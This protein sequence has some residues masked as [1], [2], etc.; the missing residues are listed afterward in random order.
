MGINDILP[1]QAGAANDFGASA[2]W[3]RTWA[4]VAAVLLLGF[5]L[6]CWNL[7]GVGYTSDEVAELHLGHASLADAVMDRDSDLFPPLY[8]ITLVGWLRAWGSDS[9]AR[10]LSVL[11]GCLTLVVVWRAGA[12]LLGE[13]DAVW[14]TL[15]L[16]T[17][18]FH[19]LHSRDGR[20]YA[21]YYLMAAL[22]FWAA[23][24]VMRRGDWGNWC[25]LIVSTAAA[26]YT[27]YF[28]GPLAVVIWGVVIATVTPRDGW[29]RALVAGAL[30][31][32]ALAPS[33]LLLWRAMPNVTDDPIVAEFDVEA[34]GYSYVSQ[35]TGHTAGPTMNELRAMPVREGVRQFLPWIGALGFAY[36]V[37]GWQAWRRLTRAQF[38][39]L[40]LPL[41]GLV[42]AMGVVGNLSGIGFVYR[43]VGWMVV[44]YAL[45]LG[46]GASRWRGNWATIAAIV[47]LL[48]VHA[49]SIY[50]RRCVPRYAEEDYRAVANTIDALDAQ[51]RPVLVASHYMGTALDYYAGDRQV[52]SFPIFASQADDREARINAFL[53]EHPAGTRFW[54]VSQWLPEDDG[55]IVARDAA[56]ARFGAQLAADLGH[57]Q[58]YSAAVP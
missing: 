7:H 34:L 8:R 11:Y 15:V 19:V 30:A 35:A 21:M 41:L 56:L 44:A 38:W 47:V 32:L 4:P 5:A 58:I 40:A 1:G 2:G 9:A 50:N 17:S 54:I 6:R 10:W 12:E 53:Q 24:R 45:L 42:P 22:I 29:Q 33:P 39:L 14:P 51:R 13:R 27:H 26:T 25:M 52:A 3:L 43:Y 46:A 18:P 37:L 28:T 20:A 36:G 23:T 48:S 55:R 31:A 16:A 49:V 57:T